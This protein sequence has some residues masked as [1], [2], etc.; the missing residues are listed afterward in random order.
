MESKGETSMGSK[1]KE[2][3]NGQKARFE[4]NLNERLAV[5][6]EAGIESREIEKDSLV[7]KLRAN[8]KAI[9]ARLKAIEANE[10]RTE[11]L[12]KMKAEKAAAPPK[13]PEVDIV[14]EKKAKAA[15]APAKEKQKKKE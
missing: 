15:P 13:S 11:G 8:I 3:Q 10:K 2:V 4:R 7:K 5:L 14:K 1:H 6:S 9:N 12:A